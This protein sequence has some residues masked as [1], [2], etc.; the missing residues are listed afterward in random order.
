MRFSI[1]IILLSLV[2]S[3]MAQSSRI[4]EDEK[5]RLENQFK[6]LKT[7]YINED[8]LVVYQ[9][10]ANESEESEFVND[11]DTI[12]PEYDQ[13]GDTMT[14]FVDENTADENL[15][16]EIEVAE[17]NSA[18]EI[19]KYIPPVSVVT[20][21]GITSISKQPINPLFVKK[22]A[23][24]P[25][26]VIAEKEEDYLYEEAKPDN[27]AAHTEEL[28]TNNAEVTPEEESV[29]SSGKKSVFE[30]R[31]PKY[32]TMEEAALAVEA[33]LDELKKEQAQTTNSG[34]MS[35]RLSGG[36]KST[37][38]KRTPANTI[39]SQYSQVNT[40]PS[41]NKNAYSDFGNEP[42]YYI[43]GRIA[44]KA[45]INMLKSKDIINRKIVTRNT[46]S[47][48]PNGEVWYDVKEY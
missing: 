47:G 28:A 15:N 29:S 44:D 6:A 24:T 35:S 42:T 12:K 18:T 9:K 31:P 16:S 38:R 30:K 25:D 23:K 14:V 10:Q 39:T 3:V 19:S 26:T 20:N 32:K 40:T 5:K 7:F 45:E 43:N 17:D 8:G 46:A 22:Q 27:E 33:L 48:N 21:N 13:T 2:T 37:L 11:D 1:I 34:S 4:D 36:A 41:V